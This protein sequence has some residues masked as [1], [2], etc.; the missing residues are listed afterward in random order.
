MAIEDKISARDYEKYRVDGEISNPQVDERISVAVQPE[1]DGEVI[2]ADN[3]LPTELAAE[4]AASDYQLASEGRLI[5]LMG[6][7]LT[8]LKIMNAYNALGH[9]EVLTEHDIEVRK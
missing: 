6:E 4:A 8:E 3:P 5:T 2:S 1:L 9:D 7:V